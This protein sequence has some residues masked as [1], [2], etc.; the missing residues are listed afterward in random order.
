METVALEEYFTGV[1]ATLNSSWGT[2]DA[3]ADV[4]QG[5]FDVR[6]VFLRRNFKFFTWPKSKEGRN[7]LGKFE[8]PSI[9][10]FSYF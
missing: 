3:I 8:V 10:T 9:L 6:L 4:N 1:I 5:K 7:Y 2:T